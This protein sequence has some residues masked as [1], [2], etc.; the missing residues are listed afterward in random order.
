MP[1][2]VPGAGRAALANTAAT[3]NARHRPA[4]FQGLLTSPQPQINCKSGLTAE[5][6]NQS[7]RN[8]IQSSPGERTEGNQMPL[9]VK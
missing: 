3:S 9:F 7:F 6:S 5:L 8:K 1:V 2:T 4:R